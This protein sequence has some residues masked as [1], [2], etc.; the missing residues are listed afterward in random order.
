ME[1]ERKSG[2]KENCK[3]LALRNPECGLPCVEMGEWPRSRFAEDQDLGLDVLS[4][5][6]L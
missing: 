6:S 1:G 5:Q 3:A 2:I 4:L